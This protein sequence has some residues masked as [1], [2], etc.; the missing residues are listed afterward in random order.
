MAEA[1]AEAEEALEIARQYVGYFQLGYTLLIVFMSLLVLG[2]VLIIRQ[3]K[4]ITRH[5]GIPLLTYGAIEYASIWVAKYFM[6]G[7]LPL[8]DIPPYLETWMLQFIDNLLNPLE[9]F[10]LGLLIGGAVLVIVSFVYRRGQT[11]D[12]G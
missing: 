8:P 7:Q 12:E 5:L 3:V 6:R 2:I 11:S 10:S 1:L 4:G 9:I